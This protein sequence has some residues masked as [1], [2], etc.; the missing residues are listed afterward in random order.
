M[1][2]VKKVSGC[3]WTETG[4]KDYLKIMSYVSTANKQ[5]INVYKVIRKTILGRPECK[6]QSSSYA[7]ENRVSGND[8]DIN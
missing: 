4:V 5:G 1:I 8:K 7:G 6:A 3:F 2:K